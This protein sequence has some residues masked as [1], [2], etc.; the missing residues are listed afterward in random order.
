MKLPTFIAVV[1]IGAIAVSGTFYSLEGG[2]ANQND[3]PT[4][5]KQVQADT[6]VPADTESV[7]FICNQGYDPETQ[8]KIPTTYAWTPRGKISI[9]RW[10]SDWFEGAGY[11]PERRCSEVSPRFERAYR[12]GNL[13]YLTNGRLNNQK[14]IC[15]VR[16]EGDNCT[17]NTLLFTLNDKSQNN[18][19]KVLDELNSIL[20]GNARKPINQSSEQQKHPDGTEKIYIDLDIE[21]FL[22]T[23]P[24]EKE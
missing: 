6:Q 24:V 14:V 11:T 17:D 8:T 12:N 5:S 13:N 16:E 23:A 3:S 7:Q 20:L 15:A 18:E 21:T 22:N 1:T 9:V 2:N 4:Q 10:K 19:R